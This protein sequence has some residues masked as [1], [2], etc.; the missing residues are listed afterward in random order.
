V[1][2]DRGMSNICDNSQIEKSLNNVVMH[3][4]QVIKN[5]AWCDISERKTFSLILTRPRSTSHLGF[6]DNRV[7]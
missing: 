4:T 2:Y 5:L 1:K 6:V 7:K 3:K